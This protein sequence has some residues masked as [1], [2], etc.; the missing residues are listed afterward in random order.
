MFRCSLYRILDSFLREIDI[1][2][3]KLGITWF[4]KPGELIKFHG[5]YVFVG[6]SNIRDDRV[7]TIGGEICYVTHC[8]DR[9]PYKEQEEY[10]DALETE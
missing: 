6:S 3:K 8:V 10:I 7:T 4:P 5:E 1:T 2:L 9:V